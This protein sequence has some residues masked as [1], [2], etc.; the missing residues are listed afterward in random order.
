MAG[1][2]VW[3][4]PGG[5]ASAELGFSICRALASTMA[6]TSGDLDISSALR[7][8]GN[9]KQAVTEFSQECDR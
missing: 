4:D 3:A 9:A 2:S 6:M 1:V 7:P 8:A 5:S